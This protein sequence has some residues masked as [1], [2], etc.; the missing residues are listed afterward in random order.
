MFISFPSIKT[1]VYMEQVHK[2]KQKC[3]QS[4]SR[5]CSSWKERFFKV[6]YFSIMASFIE[7]LDISQKSLN[8]FFK[9]MKHTCKSY[10]ILKLKQFDCSL[11]F[12]LYCWRLAVNFFFIFS[13]LSQQKVT[14]SVTSR[15]WFI[16]RSEV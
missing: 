9:T 10:A 12:Y 14:G 5:S 13:P 16:M 4:R 1:H 3:I 6:Q 2:A 8:V 15:H 11:L 7:T